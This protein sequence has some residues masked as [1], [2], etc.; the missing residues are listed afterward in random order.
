MACRKNAK[1]QFRR[2]LIFGRRVVG[3][4]S[5]SAETRLSSEGFGAA[6]C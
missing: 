6:Q 4:Y 5:S 3:G 1:E 2:F